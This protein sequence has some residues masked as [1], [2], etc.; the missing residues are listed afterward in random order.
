VAKQTGVWHRPSLNWFLSIPFALHGAP[1][2]RLFHPTADNPQQP[3]TKFSLHNMVHDA[4]STTL[5]N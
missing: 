3:L 1:V 2:A 5:G 4:L